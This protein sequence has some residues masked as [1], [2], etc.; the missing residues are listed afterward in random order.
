MVYYGTARD[1]WG[2]SNAWDDDGVDSNRLVELYIKEA[3]ARF[4]LGH[5]DIM[6]SLVEELL[7]KDLSIQQVFEVYEVKIL[8]AQAA[9]D[10]DVAI[11]VALEVRQKLGFK[12][13]PTK[14]SMLT[15]LREFRKT[16]KA[17]AGR[18]AEELAALPTLTDERVMIGQRMLELLCTSTYQGNPPM[19]PLIS[20][21]AVRSTIKYGVNRSSCDGLITY[22]VL[23]SGVFGDPKR[24]REMGRAGE[25]IVQ[26][27]EMKRMK[28]R[29]L[30]H[31]HGIN[32]HNTSPLQGT[33]RPML[34][35]YQ[36]GL[37]TGDTESA[38]WNLCFRSCYLWFAA[39]KLKDIV[40]ELR[41]SVAVLKQMNQV[42]TMMCVMPYYQAVKN[43]C[44]EEE[45][46][47]SDR[48]WALKGS[49]YDFD[50]ALDFA[51]NTAKNKM[52]AAFIIVGQLDMFVTYQQWKDA[53]GLLIKCGDLRP[54]MP[55]FFQAVRFTFLEGL[56]SL[57]IAQAAGSWR[58][59]RKWAARA[60]KSMKILR[61]G[62]AKGNCNSIHTLQLLSAEFH[63]LN[64]KREEA[65]ESFKQA[66]ISAKRAG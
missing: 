7:S 21:R 45:E 19:F 53:E 56:I 23:L 24:G 32:Y 64:G 58:E 12:A 25:L 46:M 43:L 29:V 52:L 65:G 34:E 44:G 41:T 14:P 28:S 22:G 51:E 54:F 61:V 59:K 13:I 31:V 11:S 57:K 33:L 66:Q 55:G 10:F 63:V 16:N 20:F 50:E 15:V 60:K 2:G 40:P 27:S 8:A 5:L 9:N 42:G 30:F 3:Q 4:V 6:Q 48:P 49:E 39:S 35:G 62:I 36:V 47:Q 26:S 18:S 38:C 17:V 1:L 37:Q